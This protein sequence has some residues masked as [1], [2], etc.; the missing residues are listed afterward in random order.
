M[1][2]TRQIPLTTN[3]APCSPKK[4]TSSPN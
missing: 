4:S 2:T 3:S 1:I